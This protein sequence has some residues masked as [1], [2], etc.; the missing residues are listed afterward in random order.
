[1]TTI[2][3]FFKNFLE[4][5]RIFKIFGKELTIFE[6]IYRNYNKLLKIYAN[7]RQVQQKKYKK[8]L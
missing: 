5:I 1:M 3:N 8:H 6:N 7:F 4:I 2:K